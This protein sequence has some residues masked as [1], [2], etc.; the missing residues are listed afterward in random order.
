MDHL[1]YHI[2]SQKEWQQAQDTGVYT[3][4]SLSSEGFIHCSTRAQV[5]GVGERYYRG[6]S[7][8][9]LL[10]IETARLKMELRY[11]DSHQNG[12]FFPHI[13]GPLALEAVVRAADFPPRADGLFDW[14]PDALT[15]LHAA[16]ND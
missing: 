13:Y 5:A 10:C 12:E 15:E 2:T 8:L 4:P 1:I 16:A 11:E 14:P 7:G 9:V 3:A 6:V